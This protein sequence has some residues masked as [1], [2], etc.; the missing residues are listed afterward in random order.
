MSDLCSQQDSSGLKVIFM[1]ITTSNPAPM[2]ADVQKVMFTKF[3]IPAWFWTEKN[4][5]SNGFYFADTTPPPM[6]NKPPQHTSIFR[7]LIKTTWT[8]PTAKRPGLQMGYNW[9]HLSF[10]AHW[11]S[12]TQATLVCFDLPLD[13][14]HAIHM[15]L[16]SQPLDAV[17]SHPY[18]IHAFI[19]DHVTTLYDT[20]IWKLRDTVRHNEL[21]RPTV[22]QP[23][24]NYT[25]LH[26]MARHMAH[27]TEVCGVA[28]GVMDSMLSDLQ[29]LPTTISSSTPANTAS[30]ILADMLRQRSL[31]YGFHLRCQATEARLKNE[32]ALVFH[33]AAQHESMLAQQIAQAAKEDSRAMK[34]ISVLGLV[35]LPGT[36][37][38]SLFSMS[39]FNFNPSDSLS[40]SQSADEPTWCISDRFWIYW[41]VT[42]PI[43]AITIAWWFYWQRRL[44]QK[45]HAGEGGN[46]SEIGAAEKV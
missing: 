7:F 21:H 19:L 28:L 9:Q 36:F 35:F 17:Y 43:T 24:A 8:G 2:T 23:S 39:F 27:S 1:N 30:S 13:T 15:S 6:P 32:I 40:S 25:S 38:S 3:H 14:E 11:S 37:V 12:P 34:T 44:V 29:S 20:A 22:A 45:S 26:D 16:E 41:V 18:G 31:L 42:L 4:R 5:V 10:A 33:I 46:A